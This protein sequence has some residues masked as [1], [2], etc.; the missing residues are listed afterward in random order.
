MSAT[1]P[2]LRG[3]QTVSPQHR[4]SQAALYQDVFAGPFAANAK[5]QTIFDNAAVATRYMAI[6][7]KAFYQAPQTIETRTGAYVDAAFAL[8][9]EACTRALAACGLQGSDIDFFVVASCTGFAMP[10]LDVLLGP[11]L[12]LRRDVH[13]LTIGETGSHAGIPAIARAVDHVLAHPRRRALVLVVEV[14]SV[15]FQLEPTGENVVSAAIF[16]DGATA[17]VV[18]G[19][20]V[21]TEGLA[22][23][24]G[25]TNTFFETAGEMTYRIAA[26]GLH[27]HLGRQVPDVLQSGIGSCIDEFLTK[28]GL[29]RSD[30]DRWISHPGG[31]L[32]LDRIEAVMGFTAGELATSRHVLANYGNLAAAT[33][34]F[35]LQASLAQKAPQPGERFMLL[36]YGPGLAIEALLLQA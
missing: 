3:L 13:R 33:V 2:R 32:I 10:D 21:A 6:D 8:G 18:E 28:E 5:A 17:M 24:S 20:G 1:S 15:N 30:I 19:A 36:G 14:S 34:F 4:W 26:D 9:R 31:R 25:H 7:M 27:F 12:G 35:V 11:D 23:V 29:Q 22:V 16:A